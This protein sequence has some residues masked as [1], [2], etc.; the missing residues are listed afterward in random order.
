MA[1]M[2]GSMMRTTALA[3][4]I[5]AA[6]CGPSEQD[7]Q[8]AIKEAE[9]AMTAQ[10]AEALRYVPDAFKAMMA[11]YDTAKTAFDAK[12]YKKA[13]TAAHQVTAYARRDLSAAI[14]RARQQVS[15]RLTVLR[16]SVQQMIAALDKRAG[17]RGQT[18]AAVDTLEA[19]M[20]KA[21]AAEQRGDLADALHAVMRVQ[22]DAAALSQKVG[23]K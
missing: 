7:A 18:R 10:H 21:L 3:T 14:M 23:L 15:D 17:P 16:D 12:D 8:T 22:T 20:R 4:I 11:G 2:K 6:A 19:N 5:V 1:G 13:V 9:S